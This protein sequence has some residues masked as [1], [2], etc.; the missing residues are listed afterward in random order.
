MLR[1]CISLPLPLVI[2]SPTNPPFPKWQFAPSAW[3]SNHFPK[4]VPEE[5]QILSYDLG[6]DIRDRRR[7]SASF[8]SSKLEYI[9]KDLVFDTIQQCPNLPTFFNTQKII[10][11]MQLNHQ[12]AAQNCTHFFHDSSRRCIVVSEIGSSKVL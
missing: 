8:S 6:G 12:L 7:Y 11:V 10:F 5:P 1:K 9:L 2:A 3:P 4:R